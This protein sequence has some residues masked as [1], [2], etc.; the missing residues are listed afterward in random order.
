VFC[1]GE[2][3]PKTEQI[4]EKE[5]ESFKKLDLFVQEDSHRFSGIPGSVGFRVSRIP[6]F[7]PCLLVLSVQRNEKKK[8]KKKRESITENQR[9]A[10]E[11]LQQ[12]RERARKKGKKITYIIMVYGT[13]FIS[14]TQKHRQRKQTREKRELRVQ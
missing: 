13:D 7:T 2:Q 1:F 5:K 3:I 14:V 4:S 9:A 12:M 6:C 8:N 11:R 10:N